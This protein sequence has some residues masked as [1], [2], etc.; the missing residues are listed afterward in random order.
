MIKFE[1]KKDRLEQR[2]LST[3]GKVIHR[4]EI[5]EKHVQKNKTRGNSSFNC[6]PKGLQYDTMWL[7]Y[8]EICVK[9]ELF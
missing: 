6:L 4:R 7:K 3:G 5:A 8:I 2:K 9:K 1:I